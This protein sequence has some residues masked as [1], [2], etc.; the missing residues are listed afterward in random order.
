VK[1]LLICQR[2]FLFCCAAFLFFLLA[3]VLA[4]LPESYP[5]QQ[6]TFSRVVVAQDGTPLR[7][8]A[9]KNGVWRYPVTI[10]QVSSRYIDTLLA[11]EDR[12]FYQH[13]GINPFSIM[14]AAWQNL[15]HKRS[16]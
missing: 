2:L 13:P 12:W 8:F 4:P 6:D 14:R 5:Q 7:A 9:D 10:E 1:L 3:D 16:M 15:N 11:Y